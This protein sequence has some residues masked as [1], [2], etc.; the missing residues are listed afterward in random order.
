MLYRIMM[1]GVK[2]KSVVPNRVI[3]TVIDTCFPCQHIGSKLSDMSIHYRQYT[4]TFSI[5]NYLQNHHL[6]R[7]NGQK[8]ELYYLENSKL[9][10]KSM[11]VEKKT[12]KNGQKIIEGSILSRPCA[13]FTPENDRPPG[14]PAH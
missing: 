8:L 6:W 14:L 13:M 1:H 11:F 2:L 5:L 9:H 10:T 12:V 4:H 3:R 7:K